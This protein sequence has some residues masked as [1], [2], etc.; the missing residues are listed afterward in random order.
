MFRRLV[1][2]LCIVLLFISYSF[3]YPTYK[4]SFAATE[5][6]CFD[7]F[8]NAGGDP[9]KALGGCLGIGGSSDIGGYATK[10]KDAILTNCSAYPTDH[11]VPG[12]VLVTT[13]TQTCIDPI[14][15]SSLNKISDVID[16]LHNSTNLPGNGGN[17]QCVGFV[18]GVAIG[19]DKPLPSA[20]AGEFAG[21]VPGYKWYPNG[22]STIA[23][24]DIPVWTTHIAIVIETPDPLHF[25]VAE[26]NGGNGSVGKETYPTDPEGFA[27][28]GLHLL[29][30]L[31]KQ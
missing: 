17:L 28:Y 19:I 14:K 27:L 3:I 6:N 1:S 10:L 21:D 22:T 8:I 13:D 5:S 12:Y 9:L 4:P 20:N 25:T 7:T 26:A 23:V 11:P 18:Q 15:N 31:R 2:L 29:G 30:F 24:G 16:W